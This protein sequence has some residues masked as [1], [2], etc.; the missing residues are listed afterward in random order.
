MSELER[1]RDHCREMAE[2]EHKPECRV[3]VEVKPWPRWA[4][5]HWQH[6]DPDC[7]GCNLSDDRDLFRR[8]ADEVDAYLTDDDAPLW[9]GA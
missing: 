2:A 8:L 9:E 5:A 7:L 3:F 6:P 1:F 4:P